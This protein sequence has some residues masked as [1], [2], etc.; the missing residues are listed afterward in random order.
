M[1]QNH[2][3]YL[4]KVIYVYDYILT[5]EQIHLYLPNTILGFE[6]QSVLSFYDQMVFTDT[7]F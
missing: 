4:S 2:Y 6:L 3:E 5:S 1:A 7:I